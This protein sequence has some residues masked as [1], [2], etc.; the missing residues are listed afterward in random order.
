MSRSVSQRVSP[1]ELP[2]P[3]QARLVGQVL[4]GRYKIE[5]V[6]AGG[7]MGHVYRAVQLPFERI[8]AVKV[9][10]CQDDDATNQRFRRRF[11]REASIA[12]QLSHP[13]IVTII[14]YGETD[15]GDV[16]MA[17]EHLDGKPLY[18]VL[19]ESGPFPARRALNV[20]IHR[21]RQQ[22]SRAGVGNA[23]AIVEVRRKQR[24]LG[25]DRFQIT[26]L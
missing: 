23:A 16:F 12:S 25:T 1:P 24:R 3:D 17:M 4:A 19:Q 8:V 14:D 21:A 13:N 6:I 26:K 2:T 9:L 7:A 18:R 10:Y 15:D 5:S 22:L 11:E 20:A